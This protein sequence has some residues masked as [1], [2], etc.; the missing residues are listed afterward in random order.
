MRGKR[1]LKNATNVVSFVIVIAL[2][3]LWVEYD[4]DILPGAL[5]MPAF[6]IVI[7][8]LMTLYFSIVKL[9]NVQRFS[10]IFSLSLL[11]VVIVLS[12]YQHTILHHDFKTVWKPS[13]IIWSLSCIMPYIP[14]FMYRRIAGKTSQKK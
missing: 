2:G 6:I 12:L 11:P 1:I 4:Q 7:F 14:G 10:L 8:I 5:L 9:K 3:R 13:V